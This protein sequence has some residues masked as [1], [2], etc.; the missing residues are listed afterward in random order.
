[1][2]TSTTGRRW[3]SVAKSTARPIPALPAQSPQDEVADGDGTQ[4]DHRDDRV[5]DQWRVQNSEELRRWPNATI[6]LSQ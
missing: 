4:D 6:F 1:M 2:Q 3:E 5:R